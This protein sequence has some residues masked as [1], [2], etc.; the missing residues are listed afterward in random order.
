MCNKQSRDAAITLASVGGV[1]F[2]QDYCRL[3]PWGQERERA[4]NL[5]DH[6]IALPP[7]ELFAVREQPL[8]SS[9]SSVLQLKPPESFS[10]K[11][12]IDASKI[13]VEFNSL[14]ESMSRKAKH[15]VA[16]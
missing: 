11:S 12:C 16:G 15:P 3:S 8:V 10:L 9:P 6:L 14:L 13:G 4:R 5:L 2:F 1:A 7:I